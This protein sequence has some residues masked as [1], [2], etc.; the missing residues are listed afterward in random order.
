M[1][2]IKFLRN[3]KNMIFRVTVK[4]AI[5]ESKKIIAKIKY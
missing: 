5:N 3:L 4:D 1:T 2:Q